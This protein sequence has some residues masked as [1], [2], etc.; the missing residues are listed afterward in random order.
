M[1]PSQPSAALKPRIVWI[2]VARGYG[3]LLVVVGHVQRGLV[4]SGIL[5]PTEFTRFLDSWI[6]AFHMPLFF[7]LSGLF[8]KISL[9]KGF[10]EFTAHKLRTI[11]YPYLLWSVLTVIVK[12]SLGALVNRPRELS[13]LPSILVT[14]IEQ[15]WFLYAL[16]VLTMLIGGLITVGVRLWLLAVVALVA[17]PAVLPFAASGWPPLDDTRHYAIYVMIGV[18]AHGC[19][20]IPVRIPRATSVGLSA[21]G[22][23]C[24]ALFATLTTFPGRDLV[25]PIVALIGIAATI[26]LAAATSA[27]SVGTLMQ[28]LGRH[29]LEIY[30]AHTIA[31]AGARIMLA[32]EFNIYDPT[33]HIALGIF[34]GVLGPLGLVL[35][36]RRLGVQ[37]A[38]V[39]PK[40]AQPALRG[41]LHSAEEG[42]RL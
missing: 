4:K 11:A 19:V 33:V 5:V 40:R 28:Y 16:F 7:L 22:F 13:H 23:V 26:A 24:V 31:S 8:L 42:E 14:P 35:A 10:A 30:V 9:Q 17:Y 41:S 34:A 12:A 21:L 15:F 27:T 36:L 6:Y 39:L 20:S 18:L 38:F 25:V 2:D 3:I 37:W 29:S 1:T 32:K